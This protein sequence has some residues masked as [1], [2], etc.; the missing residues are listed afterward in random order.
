[1]MDGSGTRIFPEASAGNG[2]PNAGQTAREREGQDSED[3]RGA[4]E[5]ASIGERRCRAGDSKSRSR[6]KNQGSGERGVP[7][8]VTHSTHNL[9]DNGNN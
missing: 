6:S 5:A 4:V 7:Q 3:R 9:Q 2:A 8:T 1:M